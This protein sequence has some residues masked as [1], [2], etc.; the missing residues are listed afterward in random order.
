MR[1]LTRRDSQRLGSL[2][3]GGNQFAGRL[4]AAAASP[5]APV[6]HFLELVGALQQPD[7]ARLDSAL[8]AAFHQ[9]PQQLPHLEHVVARLPAPQVLQHFARRAER[10][11]GVGG[12]AAAVRLLAS[13]PEIP[14]LEMTALADE[15]VERRQVPVH[16]LPAVKPVEH[17]EDSR[18]FAPGDS[19]R[20]R[21][22]PA[23]QVG[24]QITMARVLEDEA[25]EKPA[26]TLRQ[27]KGLEDG[28]GARMPVQHLPEVR[29][30]QPAVHRR[31]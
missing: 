12:D 29:L 17:L 9:H 14:E 15:H 4:V 10:I 28:Q 19:L 23:L 30:A 2:L 18:D 24:A 3:E 25:V 20:K 22:L 1:V 13:D 31:G 21:R 8:G 6:E 7:V 26:F 27:R 16:R 11:Q 5:D